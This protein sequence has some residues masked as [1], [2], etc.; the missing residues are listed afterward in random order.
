MFSRIRD[1][2]PPH[3]QAQ[4]HLLEPVRGPAAGR[5]RWWRRWSARA[6]RPTRSPSPR[7]WCSWL[8]AALLVVLPGHGGLAIAVVVLE[9]SYVLDCVDGQLAR[10]RGTSSPVGAHF[11]FLM[12]EL[13]AFLLVAAVADAPVGRV[14]RTCASCW[15]GCWRLTAVASGISLTTFIRRPEYRAATGAGGRAGRATTATGWPPPRRPPRPALAACGGWSAWSRAWASSWSTTR[16][17]LCTWPSPT[18]WISSCTSTGGARRLRRP[19][20]A[21]RGAE[22]GPR[23]T[24]MS[25]R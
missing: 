9:L 12:D 18:G 2:L 25:R 7:W 11:D 6:S 20:A 5:G 13:K 1:D 21:G 4:R 23:R 17:I 3:Q 10:L 8:A 14:G 24:A 22:A 15:K 19:G 16:A